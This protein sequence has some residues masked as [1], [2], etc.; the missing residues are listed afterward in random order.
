MENSQAELFSSLP[1]LSLLLSISPR[2]GKTSRKIFPFSATSPRNSRRK[3]WIFRELFCRARKLARGIYTASFL[4]P[5]NT[6]SSYRDQRKKSGEKKVVE[7]GRGGWS[8]AKVLR[9]SSS[10]GAAPGIVPRSR[11]APREVHALRVIIKLFRVTWPRNIKGSLFAPGRNEDWRKSREASQ[12]WRELSLMTVNCWRKF[13]Q[14]RNWKESSVLSPE[15]Y[16]GPMGHV[17]WTARPGMGFKSSWSITL[18]DSAIKRAR[19]SANEPS[20]T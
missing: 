16:E 2:G 5:T 6:V 11:N 20:A 18:V 3:N 14:H 1:E 7:H 10:V 12:G 15:Q 4:G 17:T 8:A 19:E 13:C 9:E